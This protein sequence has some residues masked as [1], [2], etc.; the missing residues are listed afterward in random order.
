M[1]AFSGVNA[2]Y[3]K[4]DAA[5]AVLDHALRNGF[6]QSQN[7]VSELSHDNLGFYYHESNS[8]VEALEFMYEKHKKVTGKRVRSDNNALFEHVVWLSEHQYVLLEKQYGKERV[9]RAFLQRL[10]RYAESVRAEFGFEPLGID[11]HMDEGHIDHSGRFVRNIHAHVAFFNYDFIARRAPLRHM[12]KKGKDKNGKTNS[13]NPNF[14]MLQNLVNEQFKGWGFSRGISKSITGREHLR[15]ESF[16][17]NKL[18][19]QRHSANKLAKK[20]IELEKQ[21]KFRDEKLSK[22]N[23]AIYQKEKEYKWLTNKVTKLTELKKEMAKAI[24]QKCKAALT[25]IVSKQ[26]RSTTVNK[27]KLK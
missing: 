25:S 3:Y 21:L 23:E 18:E 22:T 8:S 1:I 4:K 2:R 9:K 27:N 19:S 16:V 10:K 15:K 26:I 24:T 13:T 20:C 14:E 17:K 7:V 11:V 12:M 5:I 6:T